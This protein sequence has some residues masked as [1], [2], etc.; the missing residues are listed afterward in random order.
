MIPAADH[1]LLNARSLD[2]ETPHFQLLTND[3]LFGWQL[4]TF[5]IR[6]HFPQ[7]SV[8]L[9]F[10]KGEGSGL[11]SIS[12]LLQISQYRLAFIAIIKLWSRGSLVYTNISRTRKNLSK[13]ALSV[14]KAICQLI[15]ID[16]GVTEG[17]Q[18]HAP[19]NFWHSFVK[20]RNGWIMWH[21]YVC[22]WIIRLAKTFRRHSEI[23][24]D[25]KLT[26]PVS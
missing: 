9:A 21:Y 25:I 6:S 1:S 13:D 17:R 2:Y 23:Y 12:F 8:V 10:I 4:L 7:F 14:R 20:G 5:L 26:H 22:T 16:L 24:H 15:V 11:W 19:R 18:S 3:F